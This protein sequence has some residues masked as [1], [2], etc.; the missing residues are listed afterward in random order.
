MDSS[1]SQT[2]L[3]S[4]LEVPPSISV[5][6]LNMEVLIVED[7]L[8]NSKVMSRHFMACGLEE[9][10][11]FC[12]GNGKDAIQLVRK[13]FMQYFFFLTSNSI[14]A[15]SNIERYRLIVM[16][17]CLQ[18]GVDGFEATRKIREFDPQTP[19]FII[20]AVD[21]P[22]WPSRAR[23]AGS[24]GIFVKPVS[25]EMV[26]KMLE[27]HREVIPP[28]NRKVSDP[29]T[30][31]LLESIDVMVVS[32]NAAGHAIHAAVWKNDI[33]GIMQLLI[34]DPSLVNWTDF[35]NNGHSPLH[36]G[37][38]IGSERMLEM[39]IE[40]GA[41]VNICTRKGYNAMHVAAW[42]GLLSCVK[43]LQAKGCDST[44]V[45]CFCLFFKCLFSLFS[46]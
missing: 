10:S 38:R 27:D 12:V 29:C 24:N 15:R 25:L 7:N 37:A 42:S 16:D 1:K 3:D 32:P 5:A 18:G 35:D 19:I 4:H 34:D 26:A 44:K 22:V 11:I 13:N 36:L 46:F 23:E 28:K 14:K 9:K 45:V 39:L 31:G 17:I 41:D 40:F 33:D 8:L 6:E 43:L 21:D 20:S 2:G 30:Y